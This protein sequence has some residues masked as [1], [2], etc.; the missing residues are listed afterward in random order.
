M[1]WFLALSDG[2]PW[3]LDLYCGAGGAAVGY[4]RAG[5]RRIVGVDNAPQKHYPFEFVQADALEYL[6]EHGREYSLIHA[7]PP[8]QGYSVMNNLPWLRG[9]DYPRLIKPTRD[10]LEVIGVPWVIENVRGALWGCQNLVN[11]SARIG[12]DITSHGM[13]ADYLCG[14]MLGLP[15]YRHR[16]FES[17]FLWLRPHHPKHSFR[18][19]M[20]NSVK[21]RGEWEGV[22]EQSHPGRSEQASTAPPPRYRSGDPEKGLYEAKI[23]RPVLLPIGNGRGKRENSQQ[24]S[25]A[26]GQGNGNGAQADGVGIGHATGWKLAAEAMGIDWMNRDELTQAIPP[27]FT[28]YI[29][30]QLLAA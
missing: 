17:S 3:L 13:K 1:G 14:T 4:Y 27:I 21:P 30:G 20:P 8:C 11:I 9:R 25:L 18:Q 5:F 15:F 2:G 6:A 7:S 10:L 16:L 29:G 23:A 12:E 28:E 24:G 19:G 22:Y 26:N